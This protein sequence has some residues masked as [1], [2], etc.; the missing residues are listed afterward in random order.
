MLPLGLAS[1]Q[2][3]II[4]PTLMPIPFAKAALVIAQSGLFTFHASSGA[5]L[6]ETASASKNP[7]DC[8]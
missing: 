3:S 7:H 5:A 6:R 1:Q 2:E 4:L 8:L